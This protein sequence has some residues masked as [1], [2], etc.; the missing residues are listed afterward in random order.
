MKKI[1]LSLLFISI[2]FSVFAQAYKIDIKIVNIKNQE[3]IIGHY[4]NDQLIPD[5]TITLDNKGYGV[6]KGKEPFPGGMYFLF[7]PNKTYFDF[8]LDKDQ[9]FSITGDTSDFA[10]TVSFKGSEENI[11]FMEY[12]R[13]LRDAGKRQGDLV[14]L[15]EENKADKEKI[16]E[17]D[18]DLKSIREEMDGYYKKAIAEYPDMFFTKF[19]KATRRV[20]VPKEITDKQQQ[21]FY[22]RKHYFDPFDISDH[23]LLRTPIYKGTIDMYLDKVLMQHPDTL[24]LEVDM[25]IEKSRTNDE[26]FRF[27]LVH[28]F[29]KY[30]SSQIMSS[31]NVYVHIAEKYYIPEAKWSD[32]EFISELKT[33]IKRRKKCLIGVNASDINFRI[34]PV[35]TVKLNTLIDK[36]KI[37]K[38]D[39]LQ[40]EKSEADSLI[41]NNLKIELLKE[42]FFE[43]EEIGSLYSTDA[44]YT[45]LWFWTPDCSH[46]KKVTPKFYELYLEKKL[47][48]RNVKVLSIYMQKDIT[49]WKRFCRNNDDWLKFIK[50]NKTDEWT[51]AWNPFDLFRRNYDIKSSPVLY[52]LD[53]EK[54]IIAK[55]V[56]Y[57][58][59][60]EIIENELSREKE[61]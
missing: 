3:V 59:A 32:P 26:L 25:L 46:C 45:I 27:M 5:D 1:I 58:Q 17:I 4:F 53:K 42:F 41:K 33:K 22:F 2:I 51:N 36:S 12:Q 49:D 7:L 61:N 39:G 21:Y 43:Y 14:K 20:E 52:I 35:D 38:E 30:A 9:Q 48:E 10:N 19:L 29:N 56:G 34:V 11:V 44:E 8:L 6:F 28:L 13:S 24:I 31:E 50:E 40:V 16:K 57:E 15:R 54:K 18:A 37:L 47:N 55:R 23:R 60:I